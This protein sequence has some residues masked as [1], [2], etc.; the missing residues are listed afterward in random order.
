MSADAE[1][2]RLALALEAANQREDALERTITELHER[3]VDLDDERGRLCDA[4]T[5]A[6]QAEVEQ[7]RA[8]VERLEQALKMYGQHRSA[9]VW[10]TGRVRRCDCG[11]EAAWRGET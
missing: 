10:W 4:L 6:K 1:V 7:L 8:R 2:E 9:C 5:E 3:I 11:L